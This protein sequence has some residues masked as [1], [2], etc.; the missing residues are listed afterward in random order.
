L[1]RIGQ[2]TPFGDLPSKHSPSLKLEKL[3]KTGGNRAAVEHALDGKAV[4]Y[5][6]WVP[7]QQHTKSIPVFF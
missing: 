5:L 4:I 3:G 1:L 7:F 2:P 6:I